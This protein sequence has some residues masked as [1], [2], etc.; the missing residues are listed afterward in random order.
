M[1]ERDVKIL[2]DRLIPRP[3]KIDFRD[4]SEYLLRDN[5][6]VALNVAH[7]RGS[8]AELAGK[9]FMAYWQC[10]PDIRIGDLSGTLRGEE[11]YKISIT[12]NLLEISAHGR[13]ALLNAM[14]TL[15]QLAEVQRGT[16]TVSGYFLVQCDVDDAPALN[17]RGIH[18]CIFPETP[19][20]DIEKQLRLAAYHKFNYAVIEPW[21]VFPFESHPEFSWKNQQLDKTALKR[22]IT[23]GKDLGITLIP[24]LN[25]LGHASASRSITGKHAVLSFDPQLQPLFEP[26]GWSWC[27]TNPETRKILTDLSLELHDFFD[28]PP[29]FH[30]GCDEADNIGTCRDCRSKELKTLIKEHICFFHDLFA[31][32]NAKVIMW[33]DMLITKGDPRWKGYTACGLPEHQLGELYKELPRDI[34][35]SDW[36]YRNPETLPEDAD[37]DWPVAKFFNQENFDVLVCPW[38]N[39]NGIVEQG[40]MA[41]KR[42]LY[43]MLE[44]TW[45]IFHERHATAIHCAAA[46]V[47]WNPEQIPENSLSNR[48]ALAQHTRQ[49]DWDMGVKEYAET[50]WCKYQV[51]SGPFPLNEF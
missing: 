35:I 24:Q 39:W 29:F 27:L 47:A 38:L 45:H 37:P 16:K 6:A 23:L 4:G 30:I 36:Q 28:R 40:K 50:G 26:E 48:L 8:C 32:R 1:T 21:G 3:K 46:S 44:T 41:A 43:G 9:L 11:S 51:S 17:F 15:R 10:A 19:L 2:T 34:I 12:E 42:T 31:G 33:H 14:K 49:I 18:L 20:W 13:N 22:L 25:L 5:C 7:D